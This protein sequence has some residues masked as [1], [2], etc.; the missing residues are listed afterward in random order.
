MP[1]GCPEPSRVGRYT[2]R[3]R[4]ESFSSPARARTAVGEA[5]YRD[6]PACTRDAGDR[7]LDTPDDFSRRLIESS[8]AEAGRCHMDATPSAP[9]GAALDIGPQPHSQH[10]RPHRGRSSVPAHR[11]QVPAPFDSGLRAGQGIRTAPTCAAPGTAGWTG[12]RGP[13][14]VPIVSHQAACGWIWLHFVSAGNDA[15]KSD[16]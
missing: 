14:P 12:G 7:R 6:P 8:V 3:R 4:R 1:A 15:G 2:P 11:R 10:C 5:P 16:G 9:K 13:A